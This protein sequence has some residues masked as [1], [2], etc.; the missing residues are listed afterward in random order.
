M[1]RFRPSA[2]GGS[3]LYFTDS[4]FGNNGILNERIY[5]MERMKSNR[6]ILV[7]ACY[8]IVFRTGIRFD[9]RVIL[10][11]QVVVHARD[12][13][14]TMDIAPSGLISIFAAA[15]RWTLT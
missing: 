3:M 7:Y 15:I 9:H 14:R 4:D 1:K 2:G 5:V 13:F 10:G 12:H 8:I 11:I 6:S